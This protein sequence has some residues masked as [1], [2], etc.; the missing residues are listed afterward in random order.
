MLPLQTLDCLLLVSL[1]PILFPEL[2]T[3]VYQI[4]NVPGSYYSHYYS[5]T[6]LD[7]ILNLPKIR[8]NKNLESPLTIRRICSK[9]QGDILF[10]NR[11]LQNEHTAAPSDLKEKKKDQNDINCIKK[12]RQLFMKNIDGKLSEVGKPK[13]KLSMCRF[14]LIVENLS[15]GLIQLDGPHVC[16]AQK[17][18]S[19]VLKS[20]NYRGSIIKLFADSPMPIKHV[21]S[22]LK[23]L[24]SI[25]MGENIKH[26]VLVLNELRVISKNLKS[27]EYEMEPRLGSRDKRNPAVFEFLTAY[28]Q[29]TMSNIHL[30]K[31]G[32]ISLD[33][34]YLGG[35]DCLN[36][37]KVPK[38][39]LSD[40][41][42]IWVDS[43]THSFPA[44]NLKDMT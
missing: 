29:R 25:T 44:K 40:L 32:S 15:N 28:I 38:N 17:Y 31:Y 13:M 43:R 6:S 2:K 19:A 34:A 3:T 24:A 4:S 5:F 41:E 35:S 12:L 42:P 21:L 7:T 39:A 22:S 23:P 26:L 20:N 30:P 33:D 8:L 10:L 36:T 37:N 16:Y 1:D 11:R 18:N 9:Y 27:Q 14:E